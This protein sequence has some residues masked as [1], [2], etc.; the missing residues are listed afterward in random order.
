MLHYLLTIV[1]QHRHNCWYQMCDN[2]NISLL[3]WMLGK[4]YITSKKVSNKK[5]FGIEFW[6]KKSAS[7]YVYLPL[8]WSYGARKIDKFEVLF[9]RETVNYLQF[10]ARHCQKYTSHQKKLPIKVVQNWISSKKVRKGICLSPPPREELEGLK[11]WQ[12]R[13]IIMYWN[14]KLYSI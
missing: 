12:V 6:A 10:R 9:C 11:D 5:L 1:V 7:V 3:G 13:S 14:G 4:I 2:G 8:E